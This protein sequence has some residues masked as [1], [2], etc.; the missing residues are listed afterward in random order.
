MRILLL[1]TM[2]IL[3]D[4]S[5]TLAGEFQATAR[6]IGKEA[7]GSGARGPSGMRER[8]QV[9]EKILT[10]QQRLSPLASCVRKRKNW[11]ERHAV[12]TRHCLIIQSHHELRGFPY[13]APL[14]LT[15]L[16]L[17]KWEMI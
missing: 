10:P 17:V 8:G 4:W 7:Q 9:R 6:R 15:S 14:T 11:V 3:R 13:P 2:P 1:A 16:N 12:P 5:T